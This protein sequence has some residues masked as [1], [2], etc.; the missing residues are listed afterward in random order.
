MQRDIR[1]FASFSFWACFEKLPAQI[2]KL[3]NKNFN[4]LKKNPLHPSLHFKKAGKY[5]SVRVGKRY[6]ALGVEI[7]RGIVWFWIGTH[8]EYDKLLRG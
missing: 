5:C 4:L 3:A 2:Q 7:E 8:T 6:R 1:H